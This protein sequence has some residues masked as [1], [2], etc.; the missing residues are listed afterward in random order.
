MYFVG[1]A[2]DPVQIQYAC[3]NRAPDKPRA[4][5]N[6]GGC[7]SGRARGKPEDTGDRGSLEAW[8][9]HPSRLE[10][11]AGQ[12]ELE[13]SPEKE[14]A[15][16]NRGKQRRCD[17]RN[18]GDLTRGGGGFGGGGKMV[19]VATTTTAAG[20]TAAVE[21]GEARRV[22]VVAQGAADGATLVATTG[23]VAAALAEVT[24]GG[25]GAREDVQRGTARQPPPARLRP[26]ART[27][28]RWPW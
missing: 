28:A 2:V 24:E 14:L 16:R 18:R 19:G 21:A 26:R 13:A 17:S 23:A 6:R 1:T 3:Q 15:E 22:L 4:A 25:G 12:T 5:K 27:T 9:E 10:A 20:V 7:R 11:S 8:V